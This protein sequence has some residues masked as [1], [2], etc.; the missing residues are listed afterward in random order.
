MKLGKTLIEWEIIQDDRCV[1]AC[2][3][4]DEL[5]QYVW[6]Y[7]EDADVEVWEVKRTLV[8][9]LKRPRKEK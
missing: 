1:V 4:R 3:N 6:Q 9:T 5:N 2:H 8:Q 7:L